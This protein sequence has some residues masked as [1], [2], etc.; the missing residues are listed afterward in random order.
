MDYCKDAV[1]TEN[2]SDNAAPADDTAD[3]SDEDNAEPAE[4]EA[5]DGTPQPA[6][7]LRLQT[8]QRPQA[9]LKYLVPQALMAI[10]SRQTLTIMQAIRMSLRYKEII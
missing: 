10:P 5:T 2:S 8:H 4:G 1:I 3:D 6:K 7:P 9:Q